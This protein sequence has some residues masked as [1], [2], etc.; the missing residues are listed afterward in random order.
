M[1][2]EQA[3]FARSSAA[4]ASIRRRDPLRRP[5]RLLVLLATLAAGPTLTG[6]QRPCDD[7][8]KRLEDCVKDE[9]I[10]KTYRDPRVRERLGLRCRR[11]D[12]NRVKACLATKGC[13]K[14]SACAARAFGAAEGP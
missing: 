5:T 3:A 7:L 6:C 10:A 2:H 13:A 11:A 14:L 1:D 4:P 8:Q 12:P 9:P